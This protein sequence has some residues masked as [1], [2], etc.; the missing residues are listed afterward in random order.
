[1]VK[2]LSSPNGWMRTTASR[3]LYERRD[4]AAAALLKPL[5][6]DPGPAGLAVVWLVD[7]LTG[8]TADELSSAMA[9]SL[10]ATRAT[11]V[12]LSE[13][14]LA[15][16]PTAE[17]LGAVQKLAD[18]PDQLVRLQV[19]LSM[20][21]MS[22]PEKVATLAQ[23]VRRDGVNPLVR[24]AIVN[25]AAGQEASLCRALAGDSK[26]NGLVR[27]IA[28]VIGQRNQPSEVAEIV[29]TAA[30]LYQS[31]AAADAF[32]LLAAL[33]EGQR[34]A[35]G[36]V[37]ESD[38]D[39]LLAAAQG[40]AVD[41]HQGEATRVTAI[42]LLATS[43]FAAA[44]KALLACLTPDAPQAVQ[45]AAITALGEMDDLE[46]GPALVQ[47]FKRLSPR[48]RSETLGVLLL[49]PDRAMAL[50][51]GISSGQLRAQDLPSTQAMFLRNH[52]DPQVQALARKL[53]IP[54]TGTRDDV[55]A[56][57]RSALSLQGDAKAGKLVYEARC[58]SCH[59]V[60]GEGSSVGPDLM[61]VR[62]AGK[63]K[64]LVNILDPNREVAPNFLAYLVE[65]RDGESLTGIIVNETAASLTVR[66]A[67]GKDTVV[68]RSD[69]KRMESQKMTL[70]PEGLE[71][72]L[73]PQDF[74]N[75][76]EFLLTAPAE[77]H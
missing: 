27:G 2:L 15:E 26:A 30:G 22:G 51:N 76:L 9:N 41:G 18:D 8:S 19:A 6:G 28:Q 68:M 74:A 56:Q 38:S 23:I 43:D 54:P 44:G 58:I 45:S 16:H 64:M 39:P 33:R 75:L 71:A 72:G 3:L 17:L 1:L 59:H 34:R 70:M 40:V 12:K 10:P 14:L 69:V 48:L 50:L 7:G 24:A 4:P 37:Q 5:L 53:L 60:A 57:Y 61:T 46:V 66:Q 73:K 63:E 42:S 52:R 29:N 77:K 62:S 20:G 13:P 11:A 65:T 35:V 67:Y 55:I 31:G 36:H 32:G 47:H 49:R 25:A 21:A